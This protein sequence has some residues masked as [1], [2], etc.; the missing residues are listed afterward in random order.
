MDTFEFNK[1]VGALL[2]TCL[3]VLSLNIAAGVIFSPTKP[4]KP[5]YAIATPDAPAA[6]AKPAEGAPEEPIETLLAKASAQA[7]EKDAKLCAACHTFDKGGPNRVGPNL[8][9]V[10]GRD[11]GAVPGFAYSA[12]M[13][14]AK[15]NWTPEDL[16]KFLLNPKGSIPGTAMSFAG[17]AR[18]SQRADIIAF[19]NSKSDNPAPLTK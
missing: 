14:S 13:K 18:A 15:G 4:A 3:V 1:I 16:N 2:F 5:G 11:K 17:V 12:A 9:G 7:G 6:E 8:Y 10:L 19:L